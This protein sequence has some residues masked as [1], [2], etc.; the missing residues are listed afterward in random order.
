M[1]SLK[2]GLT[3]ERVGER[4]STYSCFRPPVYKMNLVLYAGEKGEHGPISIP[5]EIRMCH[6]CK[7]EATVEKVV[8]DP[9]WKQLMEMWRSDPKAMLPNREF[10]QIEFRPFVQVYRS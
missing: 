5:S 2:R 7:N 3:K 8:H 10:T 9:M 1:G 6:E 4:C